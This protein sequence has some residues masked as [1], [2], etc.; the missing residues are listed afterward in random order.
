MGGIVGVGPGDG[1][2]RGT[3]MPGGPKVKAPMLTPIDPAGAGAA[4]ATMVR[5]AMAG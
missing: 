3:V 2:A 4:L 5:P 1:L